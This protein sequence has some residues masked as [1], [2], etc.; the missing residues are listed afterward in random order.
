M[1]LVSRRHMISRT[2]SSVR[3]SYTSISDEQ[4][5]SLFNV[6][7][8]FTAFQGF[9]KVKRTKECRGARE[10]ESCSFHETQH[11]QPDERKSPKKKSYIGA[12][13]IV[14]VRQEN[15]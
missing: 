1:E 3:T 9:L 7:Y 4:S 10:A 11:H 13:G 12:P 14:T 8:T 2:S 5:L 6:N 15:C